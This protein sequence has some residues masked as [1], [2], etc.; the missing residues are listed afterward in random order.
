MRLPRA[1]VITDSIF[2]QPSF[3]QARFAARILYR[4]RVRRIQAPHKS[5][6]WSAPGGA[7]VFNLPH[8]LSKIGAPP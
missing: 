5:R 7:P 3:K 2:K 6:G 1:R 8:S 4:R